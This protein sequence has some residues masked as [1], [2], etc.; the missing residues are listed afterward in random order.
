M[1]L[2]ILLIF[3]IRKL[4]NKEK[5]I[6]PAFKLLLMMFVSTYHLYQ[7]FL[8]LEHR[9]LKTVSIF[10]NDGIV[11]EINDYRKQQNYSLVSKDFL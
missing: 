2:F 3:G 1:P 6:K 7:I 11:S 8:G 5:I 4:V 9:G 10:N